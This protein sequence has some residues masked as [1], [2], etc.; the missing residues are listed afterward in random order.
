MICYI[1]GVQIEKKQL[2]FKIYSP[3]RIMSAYDDLF[4]NFYNKI[5]KSVSIIFIM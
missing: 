4:V 1:N 5:V 3:I 2:Y